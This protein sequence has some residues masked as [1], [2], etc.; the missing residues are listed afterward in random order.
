M[1][2]KHQKTLLKGTSV[3]GIVEILRL[4]LRLI[5]NKFASLL[6]GTAGVGLL[7]LIDNTMQLISSFSSFGIYV[8]GIREISAHRK[9]P[10]EFAR[11]ARTVH[12]FSVFSGILAAI[13]SLCF[14]SMLSKLTFDSTDYTIWFV[15]LSVYFVA[16]GFIQSKTILLE[17]LQEI[18]KLLKINL[19]INFFNSAIA[20]FSYYYWGISGIIIAMTANSLFSMFL[21]LLKTRKMIPKVVISNKEL[22]ADFRKLVYSGS[23]IASNMVIGFICFL[24]IRSFFKNNE[25]LSVL[26]LYN[27]GIT[28]L[29]SYLGMI[30]IAMSKIFFPK[31][32]LAVANKENYNEL[33]NNQL[34]ICLLLVL[35]VILFIYIFNKPLIGLLFSKAFL[36]V[37]DILIFGLASMIFKSFN[38]VTGYLILSHNNYKQYFFINAFSDILNVILTI[39]FYKI[40]GLYGIGFSMFSNYAI[41]SIYQYLYAKK[42]YSFEINKKTGIFLLLSIGAIILIL[43]TYFWMNDRIFFVTSGGLF[44]ITG[45]YSLRSINNYY[46]NGLLISRVKNKLRKG[47]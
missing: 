44:I 12:Y 43:G 30:F 36:S 45:I 32:S 16:N 6:L 22:A 47:K 2:E 23:V 35:P 4:V 13:I 25:S 31:I 18:H 39:F 46:F 28:L 17:S 29:S 19:I 33:A 9:D 14:S 1:K 7:G 21:Y 8:T 24:L 27:V 10:A 38:Y 41:F 26:G 37:S 11:K 5:Y 3:F 42:V 34:E 40:W 20:I 15:V